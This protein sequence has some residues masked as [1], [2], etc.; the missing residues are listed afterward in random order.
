MI[1]KYLN[2][3]KSHEKG[4]ITK[5]RIV[6]HTHLNFKFKLVLYFSSLYNKEIVTA[7]ISW[8]SKKFILI[9][10]AECTIRILF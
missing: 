8:T 1:V 5:K 4:L 2:Y 3:K 6:T 9:I 7:Y 10:H